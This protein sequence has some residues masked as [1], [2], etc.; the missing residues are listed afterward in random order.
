MSDLEARTQP[1]WHAI[2]SLDPKAVAT[3]ETR[4]T[5]LTLVAALARTGA[6]Q[7]L[8][9]PTPASLDTFQ[10]DKTNL[11]FPA[12][13]EYVG[14]CLLSCVDVT[15][16]SVAQLAEH[17]AQDD[18]KLWVA[19][20]FQD[21]CT[22]LYVLFEE[23]L[24]LL[25]RHYTRAVGRAAI[26]EAV[27]ELYDI[28]VNGVIKKGILRKKGDRVKTWKERW[29]VLNADQMVYYTGRDEKERKGAI[30]LSTQSVVQ[31]T[32]DRKTNYPNRFTVMSRRGDR[33][34]DIS[35]IDNRTLAGQEWVTVVQIGA[36]QQ[37]RGR[38]RSEASYQRIALAG[39]ERR[40]GDMLK[41]A[42]SRRETS[43]AVDQ[44]QTG[45]A[46]S[47]MRDSHG[48]TGESEASTQPCKFI[49]NV[50]PVI[51]LLEEEAEKAREL[52]RLSKEQEGLLHDERRKREEVET[53]QQNVSRLLMEERDR[54]AKLRTDRQE[55]ERQ[56]TEALGKLQAA[57]VARQRVEEAKRDRQK[58]VGLARLIQPSAKPLVSHR[59][60]GAFCP[61]DFKVGGRGSRSSETS[62]DRPSYVRTSEVRRQEANKS[63]KTGEDDEVEGSSSLQGHVLTRTYSQSQHEPQENVSQSEQVVREGVAHS[64]DDASTKPAEHRRSEHLREQH[65]SKEI[66]E[67]HRS[68]KHGERDVSEQ[69]GIR[70]EQHSNEPE[71]HSIRSEQH[72]NEPEQEQHSNRSEQHSNRSEQHSNEPEQHSR[73]SEQ[74]NQHNVSEQYSDLVEQQSKCDV[75]EQQNQ[76]DVSEQ[77]IQHDVSEQQSPHD[78]SEQLS[79]HDIS[80]QLSPHYV[81]EQLSPHDLSEQ[82]SPHDV[83][84]QLNEQH[85]QHD[86]SEQQN[87]HDVDQQ[88]SLHDESE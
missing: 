87:L 10:P 63:G 58:P 43:C 45:R 69:H 23:M 14:R 12:V 5:V 39:E 4:L 41:R 3:P 9:T 26:S 65:D 13:A 48:E 73:A 36:I 32:P 71:Q 64:K 67:H 7:S 24:E 66:E 74:H 1:L 50:I 72:S 27:R 49:R 31:M 30:A 11:D 77:Q 57:E 81:S 52:E 15:T 34:F 21:Q 59:G 88:Q 28:F 33:I 8:Q 2:H 17:P 19:E 42:R 62:R 35:A 82:L 86:V 40:R 68:E 46:A 29:F 83:S 22:S 38:S 85:S 60:V 70:S 51:L 78:L 61:W 55:A 84:E 54:M 16:S 18:G 6:G 79:P 53:E 56:L 47:A 75:S 37:F 25:E 80:E 76:H 20:A 44:R